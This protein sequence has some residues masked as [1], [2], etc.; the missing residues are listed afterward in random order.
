LPLLAWS[1][2]RFE[3]GGGVEGDRVVDTGDNEALGDRFGGA[4]QHDGFGHPAELVEGG[5]EGVVLLDHEGPGHADGVL[6][7]AL[8][9]RLQGYV[10]DSTDPNVAGAE[11]SGD[12]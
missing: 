5:D 7:G 2:Q 9:A 12:G 1:S 3:G 8:E 11:D 4:A 6:P 10:E